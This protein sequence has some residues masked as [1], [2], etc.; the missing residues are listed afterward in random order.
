MR[1][2]WL[3]WAGVE[4]EAAGET[5]VIDPLLDARAVFAALGDSFPDEVVPAVVPCAAGRARAGLLTHLHRDHTDAG[6]LAAALAPGA[7]VWSPASAGGGERENLGLAQALAE[8]SAAGLARREMAPWEGGHAGPF[9]LIA[10]PAADGLGDPQVSWMVAAEGR[11]IVHLG[12]TVFHGALWRIAQRHGP[13]DVVLVPIN[14]AVVD[15]PHRQPPSPAPAV[16]DPEQ[17]A[18]AAELLGAAVAIPIHY[19]GYELAPFYRPAADALDRFSRAAR[20]HGLEARTLELGAS[21]E[22]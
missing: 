15:F 10:L 8:L 14:G 4:V 17:A 13:F 21:H 11:R 1:V 20:Q 6:A 16:L 12:D 18:L 9:E 2:R 22:F 5:V 7:E 19:G 3:G